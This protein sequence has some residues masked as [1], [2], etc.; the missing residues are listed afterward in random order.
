MWKKKF[1]LES[2]RHLPGIYQI[3]EKYKMELEKVREFP[4][5][6]NSRLGQ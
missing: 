3:T 6:L 4:F 2:K 1:D 5:D